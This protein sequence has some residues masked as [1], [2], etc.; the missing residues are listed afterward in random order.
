MIQ[1]KYTDSQSGLAN[2]FYFSFLLKQYV[3]EQYLEINQAGAGA[4]S[5]YFIDLLK[6]NNMFDG[7]SEHYH[8]LIRSSIYDCLYK[9]SIPFRMVYDENCDMVRF[10]IGEDYLNYREEI[11]NTIK[12][13]I[14]RSQQSK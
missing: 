1:I 9:D 11:D 12:S 7:K 14:E 3:P 6:Q 10:A 5:Y 8:E 2:G 4:E 13:L